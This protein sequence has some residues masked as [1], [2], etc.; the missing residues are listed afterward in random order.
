M[1]SVIDIRKTTEEIMS[2]N[3]SDIE[4]RFLKYY[5]EILANNDLI[6]KYR[7]KFNMKGYLRAYINVTQ[8]KSKSPEFSIRYGGQEVALMRFNKKKEIFDLHFN[9][10]KHVKNNNKL[11]G[12]DIE[13]GNYEWKDSSEA[14]EFRKRFEKIP[15]IDSHGIGEHWYESFILDE[16]QNPRGDKFCGNYKY[17][18]P[19]LIAGK[20]PFQMPV[21]ISAIGGIPKYQKGPQAGHIDILARH[22]KSK[23]TL[24]VIELKRPGGQYDNAISQAII[25]TVTLSYLIQK[26]KSDLGITLWRLCGYGGNIYSKV[27]FN[28]VVA[29]PEESKAMYDKEL[30]QL[31][32]DIEGS[33]ISLK[34][35]VYRIVDNYKVDIVDTDLIA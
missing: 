28:S 24:S 21:P 9:Q 12:F 26:A 4:K 17:I 22:G 18:K 11:F 3:W 31:L 34:Y 30:E 2:K 35:L 13:P 32:P 16:L 33:N 7:K 27:K 5:Q 8:A 23:P 15:P 29:I 19:V 14:K 10:A 25:Y 20:I 6:I 1:K